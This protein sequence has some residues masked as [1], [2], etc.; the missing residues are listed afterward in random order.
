M[1]EFS[2]ARA[3]FSTVMDS[4]PRDQALVSVVVHIG[5]ARAVEP[6]LLRSAWCAFTQD[7]VHF[8]GSRLEISS[9]PWQ[10]RCRRCGREFASKE[11]DLSCTCGGKT[12]LREMG[13]ELWIESIEVR[14]L[15]PALLEM[16]P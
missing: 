7:D 14:P 9:E 15:H 13:Q 16:E 1:H 2:L 10:L 11:W 4:C 12:Q 5:A 3:L 8:C 6:E